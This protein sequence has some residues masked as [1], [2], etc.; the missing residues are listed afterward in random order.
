MNEI[1]IDLIQYIESK[2]NRRKKIKLKYNINTIDNIY[3]IYII[4]QEKRIMINNN[5]ELSECNIVKT[6][7]NIDKILKEL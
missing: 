5:S 4:N 3:T 7:I 2:N 1:I 6:I